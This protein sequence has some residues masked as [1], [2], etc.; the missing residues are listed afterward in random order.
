ML[1][2]ITVPFIFLAGLAAAASVKVRSSVLSSFIKLMNIRQRSQ[3]PNSKNSAI[4]PECC[5][6]YD[7]AD[8]LQAENHFD[9][10]C[11][12]DG[13]LPMHERFPGC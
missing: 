7:L 10:E 5:V 6:F 4:N 9:S 12:E 8:A 13:G 3:C 1:I 11:A 2:S